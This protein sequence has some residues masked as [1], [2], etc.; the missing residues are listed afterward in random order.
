MKVLDVNPFQSGIDATIKNID[1]HK[2]QIKSLSITLK[3]FMSLTDEFKGAGADAI[4]TFYQESHFPFL[5][6]Y[7]RVL[8]EYRRML[9]G[10]AEAIQTVEPN[11]K[12][13]I[14]EAFIDHDVKNAFVTLNNTVVSL[15]DEVNETL[16]S[17]KDIVSLNSINDGKIIDGIQS[18]QKNADDTV[19]KMLEMDSQQSK[20]LDSISENVKVLR[21]YVSEIQG[22]FSGNKMSVNGFKISQLQE[23][24]S[25]QKLKDKLSGLDW[26]S[27]KIANTGMLFDA[28]VPFSSISNGFGTISDL[29]AIGETAYGVIGK[30]LKITKSGKFY[31]VQGGTAIGLKT[32]KLKKFHK[33]YIESQE[34]LGNRLEIA[35]QVKASSAVVDVFKSKIGW[36]G[37]ALTTGEN[38]YDNIQ[39]HESVTKISGDAAVDVGVGAIA[40]A[41][42][43]ALTAAVVG[44]VGLPVLGAAAIGFAGSLGVS[45]VLEGIKVG[46]EEKSISDT[47]KDGVQAGINTIAGWLK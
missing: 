28:T 19:Q 8:S 23:V 41:G 35:K 16:D 40:L 12:G 17:I 42:G 44:T 3:S 10:M 39:A 37:I 2:E 34:K 29:V 47:L 25:Y 38:M 22:R 31:Y 33:N 36:A 13:F 30:G 43:A 4:R 24:E 18:V 27:L 32:D 20:S 14:R 9:K 46:K 5:M 45:Y 15:T 21:S 7:E 11:E 1:E 6:Y 26:T